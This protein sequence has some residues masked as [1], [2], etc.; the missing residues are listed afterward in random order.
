MNEAVTLGVLGAPVYAY[1]LSVML[2][3]WA[4]IALLAS[5][6]RHQEV[7]RKAAA[8]TAALSLPLGF[9]LAR[10][11]YCLA[12]P[13]F[14]PFLSIEN[15]LQVSSG[16][17]AMYGALLGAALAALAGARLAGI[18]PARMLDFLAPALAAF[19]IP[20]RLGE[21]FTALGISRPLTTPWLAGSFLALRDAYDAYLR[22]YL[23]EA[24]IAACL[25]VVLLR[26]LK[27]GK[28]EGQ[29]FL[30]FTLLYGV[31]QT[32]ME[33]LRYDGHLRFSFIGLQ[34]VL[35]AALFSLTLIALAIRLLKRKDAKHGLAILALVLIPIIL[36]AIVG[37]EFLIDRSEL[38]KLFSY[39]Q[40]LLVLVIPASLGILL[41]KT[42]ERFGQAAH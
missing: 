29:V 15:L 16:G 42:E 38:G 25:L 8:I 23:L 9:V 39:A 24:L 6:S 33:S 21:G 5:L 17:F 13:A 36:G 41:L 19:L 40:Y 3:C 31:T 4:A 1:G 12:D 10:L 7:E 35:S 27:R 28:R 14:A 20:A 26:A 2:G 11:L 34:Q 22:T 37:V 30:L 32:L 18:R